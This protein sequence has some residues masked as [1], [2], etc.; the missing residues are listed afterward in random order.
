MTNAAFNTQATTKTVRSLAKFFGIP[1]S[2]SY[3]DA[4]YVNGQDRTVVFRVDAQRGAKMAE[5][6]N[7]A[8]HDLGFTD[9]RARY[10]NTK[11]WGYVRVARATIA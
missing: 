2:G 10:T 4:P 6:L 5:A 9:T 11:G 8:L 7:S 3:T 1:A